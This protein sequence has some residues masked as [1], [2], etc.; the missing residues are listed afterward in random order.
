MSR[1]PL[2]FILLTISGALAIPSFIAQRR[3]DDNA[4]RYEME[5]STAIFSGTYVF[6]QV[7]PLRFNFMITAKGECPEPPLVFL[8]S[9]TSGLTM[10][11]SMT[12]D[13]DTIR[14]S[15]E[16][17]QSSDIGKELILIVPSTD[18]CDFE[19]QQQSS[20]DLVLPICR[21]GEQL[22]VDFELPTTENEPDF[23][24]QDFMD[25]FTEP[26]VVKEIPH[27]LAGLLLVDAI[28]DYV[29]YDYKRQWDTMAKAERQVREGPYRLIREIYLKMKPFITGDLAQQKEAEATAQ[30][31]CAHLNSCIDNPRQR[32]DFKT[33]T[34]SVFSTKWKRF[35]LHQLTTFPGMI[36]SKKESHLGQCQ[37][38]STRSKVLPDG[39]Y[40]F[41]RLLQVPALQS[42]NFDFHIKASDTSCLQ[43][44]PSV[45]LRDSI[46]A[47]N[48]GTISTESEMI[49]IAGQIQSSED[50]E[51]ILSIPT[52]KTCVYELVQASLTLQLPTSEILDRFCRIGDLLDIEW[53]E[54]EVLEPEMLKLIGPEILAGVGET[55]YDLTRDSPEIPKSLAGLSLIDGIW[56]YVR[57]N[58]EATWNGLSKAE[59][60]DVM[61]VHDKLRGVYK[62]LQPYST[63]D[64]SQRSNVEAAARA[65]C[66]YLNSL[67]RNPQQQ[68]NFQTISL[69]SF[70][71][72][73]SKFATEIKPTITPEDPSH[74]P[75]HLVDLRLIDAIHNYAVYDYKGQWDA[76][77]AE[78]RKHF[79]NGYKMIRVAYLR[80]LP[81]K[82]GD[83]RDKAQ[84]EATVQTAVKS[85][86]PHTLRSDYETMTLSAFY[87]KIN[88]RKPR[89]RF[90][91]EE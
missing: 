11:G 13:A 76:F 9:Q 36:I 77:S 81:F 8:R 43:H 68:I 88:T 14:L 32:V 74:V 73:W 90:R 3:E 26:Q 27:S 57:L 10:T 4:C 49:R 47:Q 6:Q 45:L 89:Q 19:I 30:A 17:F 51:L 22:F 29:R 75:A 86:V 44:L 39:T 50:H 67:I 42:L 35:T 60:K 55:V 69:V 21:T 2:V 12:T 15:D 61:Y 20:L 58:Y 33:I 7:Q 66:E 41:R 83:L 85:L 46:E 91:T 24:S 59:R 80:I 53:E 28:R 79:R 64:L 72:K 70:Q 84:V 40:A 48:V 87:N 63:G 54:T 23:V 31:A 25:L 78:E 56:N 71:K 5:K 18:E 62:R 65:A 82:T 38:S 52:S 16:N 34:L 37:V 1:R